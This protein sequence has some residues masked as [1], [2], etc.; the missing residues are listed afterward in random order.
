MFSRILLFSL[1]VVF[2]TKCCFGLIHHTYSYIHYFFPI[3]SNFY[4]N[5]RNASTVRPYELFLDK[6]HCSVVDDG[7]SFVV[8]PI[9]CG[10]YV[11]LA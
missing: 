5:G 8:A 4:R 11:S 7:W 1:T 6:L 3:E 10:V 2:S 9:V